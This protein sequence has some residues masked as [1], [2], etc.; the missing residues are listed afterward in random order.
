MH[1]ASR[2]PQ[3]TARSRAAA[4]FLVNLTTTLVLAKHRYDRWYCP[5]P[6]CMRHTFPR[7]ILWKA[8]DAHPSR[9]ERYMSQL[10]PEE[11]WKEVQR[12]RE[13]NERLKKYGNE[14][15]PENL[16][17][18]PITDNRAIGLPLEDGKFLPFSV[19]EVKKPQYRIVPILGEAYLVER[20]LFVKDKNIIWKAGWQDLAWENEDVLPDLWSKCRVPDKSGQVAHVVVPSCEIISDET[21]P[22]GVFI[23]ASLLRVS[24]ADN[25]DHKVLMI[26]ETEQDYIQEHDRNSG[27]WLWRCPERNPTVLQ[28]GWLK[29]TETAYEPVGRLLLCISPKI[30]TSY[31]QE[32]QTFLEVDEVF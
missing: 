28:I 23:P 7:K 18:E 30:E 32:A 19:V 2:R 21:R 14:S 3:A 22:L 4:G 6:Y 16:Q 12:L 15:A 9:S 10:S 17:V 26:F 24:F 13:E 27:I 31:D 5:F 11:L 8:T 25:R 29:Q 1:C 20:E